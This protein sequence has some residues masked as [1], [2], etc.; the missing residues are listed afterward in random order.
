MN[1]K[2][3]GITACALILLAIFVLPTGASASDTLIAVVYLKDGTQVEGILLQ[4]AAEQV[5]IDPDGP[6]SLRTIPADEIERVEISETGQVYRYPLS[7]ANIDTDLQEDAY[8]A[9]QRSTDGLRPFAFLFS[10]GFTATTG[11]YYEGAGSG[12]GFQGGFQYRFAETDPWGSSFFLGCNFRYSMPG[13]DTDRLYVGTDGI[14]DVYIVYDD[15]TVKE[16]SFE[17]GRTT[18]LSK[19]ETYGY[20]IAG[21]AAVW[22]TG[23]AYLEA[24][25]ERVGTEES[26]SE[27][28]AA[29]R[30]QLGGVIG[31][32]PQLGL[33][34]R[35]G[36]DFL[37]TKSSSASGSYYGYYGDSPSVAG[38]LLMFDAGVVW[39]L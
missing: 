25:G 4:L 27:S 23:S 31:L 33:D 12:F 2:R 5:R 8:A 34:L 6:V 26:Y 37:L 24:G 22:T 9:Q 39:E 17:A 10:L 35:G 7:A 13:W 30:F 28:K 14:D 20:M 38:V 15:L 32:S 29:F 16:L 18:R 1:K 21:L 36:A 3:V 11:D 19:T